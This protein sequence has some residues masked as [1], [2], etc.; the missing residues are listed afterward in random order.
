MDDVMALVRHDRPGEPVD[1]EV[2]RGSRTIR[3]TA[4]ARRHGHAV[5]S[6]RGPGLAG[7]GPDH[8]APRSGP[9]RCRGLDR[10]HAVARAAALQG[11][12]A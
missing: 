9:G 4:T 1:V 7:A 5:S 3:V 10:E 12:H 2:Q 8:S 11:E 6:G